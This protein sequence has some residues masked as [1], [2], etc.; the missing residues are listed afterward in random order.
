MRA[1][2]RSVSL[3][4]AVLLFAAVNSTPATATTPAVPPGSAPTQATDLGALNQNFRALYQGRTRQV[5]QELPLVLVVQNSAITA[6]RGTR[7]TPYPVDL[8]HYTQV[9]SISH[10]VLGFHGLMRQLEHAGPS[11]DW[12]QAQ[13]FL[14]RLN[15]LDSH[16]DPSALDPTEKQQAAQLLHAL[17]N[18]T[19]EAIR[20]GEIRLSDTRATLQSVRPML[21][22]LALSAGQRHVQ[23]M[24]EVLQHI[25]Q[26]ASPA[27]WSGAVAVVTG[28]MTPRRNNLETAITASVLGADQLGHRIFYAESVFTVDGALSWLQTVIGDRELSENLFDDPYRMWEDLLAPVAKTL[29]ETDFYTELPTRP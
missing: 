7:Q 3:T 1:R 20:A 26:D 29:I 15:A 28:P 11:A 5:L 13:R 9:K 18:T 23:I 16:I 12:R 14:E 25:R 22:A 2:F 19:Q 4:A 10:A 17:K 24:Q 6:V 27:E 21:D 8:T